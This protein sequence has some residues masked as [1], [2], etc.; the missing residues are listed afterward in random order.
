MTQASLTQL[1]TM[2]SSE[3][4]VNLDEELA[5]MVAQQHIYAA[6]ARLLSTYDQ[7]LDTLIQRTGV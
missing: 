6:S 1:E 3:S 7:M 4:G 5:T 2:Q